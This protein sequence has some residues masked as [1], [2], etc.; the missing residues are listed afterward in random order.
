MEMSETKKVEELEI[1]IEGIKKG[2]KIDKR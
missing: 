2:L 1:K